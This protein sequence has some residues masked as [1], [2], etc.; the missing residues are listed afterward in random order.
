MDHPNPRSTA[1]IGGHP[2]HP[3]LIPIPITCFIGTLVADLIFLW[4]GNAEWAT[5][6]KWLLGF[7]IAGAL[8]AASAGLTDYFG[9]ERIRRLD[10]ARKHMIANITLVAIEAINLVLRFGNDSAIAS[11]GV[12][13]SVLAV[14]ILGYSGW[15]GGNLVFHHRV[16]VQDP[17]AHANEERR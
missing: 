16:G 12:Y 17:E 14:A 3:M 8:L 4:T 10:H 13:L 7:G 1:S 9:D 11:V 6:S 2:I 15:L 5:A